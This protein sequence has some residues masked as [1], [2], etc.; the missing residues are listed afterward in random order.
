MH[1]GKKRFEC[2]YCMI[3]CYSFAG[4]YSVLS[5]VQSLPVIWL[6]LLSRRKLFLFGNLLY[7]LPCQRYKC[8]SI[9]Q[10]ILSLERW[11][12]R[13]RE[14]EYCRSAAKASGLSNAMSKNCSSPSMLLGHT[15]FAQTKKMC[16][17]SYGGY[18]SDDSRAT[19]QCY[20]KNGNDRCSPTVLC[21]ASGTCEAATTWRLLV[22][23]CW[24]S[25]LSM[26]MHK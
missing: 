1:W 22:S 4:I 18:G 8:W 24:Q 13:M 23:L 25:F 2:I 9:S 5:C 21:F 11:E 17:T 20:M 14:N 26:M 19:I 7:D 12:W 6:S 16:S 3:V 15:N 10:A